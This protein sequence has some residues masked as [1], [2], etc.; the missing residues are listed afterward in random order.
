MTLTGAGDMVGIDPATAW[1]IDDRYLKRTLPE[2]RLNKLTHLMVNERAVRRRLGYVIFVL[3]AVTGEPLH[4][5]EGKSE[6]AW[7]RF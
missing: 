6:T 5:A 4:C 1:R 2:S 7:G 3:N